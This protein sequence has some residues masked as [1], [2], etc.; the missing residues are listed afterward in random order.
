VFATVAVIG[1]VVGAILVLHARRALAPRATPAQCTALLNR[2]VEHL[3]HAAEPHPAASTIAA[4][5][6]LAQKE[7]RQ[8]PVFASCPRRLSHQDADCALEAHN[9]DEFERCLQ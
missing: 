2:Y 4:Q 5:R 9:A 3:A 7:A 8:S 1:A 6:I